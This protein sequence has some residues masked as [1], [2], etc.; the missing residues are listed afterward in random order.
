M[1][2]SPSQLASPLAGMSPFNDIMFSPMTDGILFSPASGGGAGYR[3]GV[4]GPVVLVISLSTPWN[5]L[6]WR[7]GHGMCD[8]AACRLA[9]AAAAV[10]CQ[11]GL[12]VLPGV[13]HSWQC[14]ALRWASILHLGAR[15]SAGCLLGRR[16]HHSFQWSYSVVHAW[17]SAAPHHPATAQLHLATAPRLPATAPPGKLPP[18]EVQGQQQQQQQGRGQLPAALYAGPQ[19]VLFSLLERFPNALQELQGCQAGMPREP[20]DMDCP[21]LSLPC[22]CIVSP[23]PEPA[24][25]LETCL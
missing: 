11:A 9:W 12:A 7:C 3:C 13:L 8:C 16:V 2:M 21:G 15:S 17:C 18:A 5:A 25:A 14:T 23:I 10:P 22:A 19:L 4:G 6:C 1:R 24:V 20:A